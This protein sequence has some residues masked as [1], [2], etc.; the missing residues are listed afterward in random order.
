[1]Q[2]LN[3]LDSYES[4]LHHAI[5]D[6][7][8]GINPV[9]YTHLDVYK[10]QGQTL[11]CRV[12]E[13]RPQER[14]SPERIANNYAADLLMPRYLF[15]RTARSYPKLN[16]KT[17]DDIGGIFHTSRP[18]TTI[19]LV[20]GSHSPAM[21]VCHGSARRKWFTRGADVPSRWFPKDDLDTDSFAFG[22]LHAGKPDDP[23]PRKIG[24]DAWFDRWEAEKYEVH[25]QN[26]R[27]GT[28]EVLTPVSYTHL[29]V[30]KRQSIPL[31]VTISFR[32]PSTGRSPAAGNA[33]VMSTS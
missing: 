30:Y 29:D 20:E 11:V 4:T 17:V 14:M 16:F 21:L 2:H 9:S 19:R 28:D 27:T 26:I 23:M 24:A 22:V 31:A 25:E 13:S 33:R 8:E 12:E 32:R 6:R 3:L 5:Q 18:A 15:A 1:L 10:R 7:K